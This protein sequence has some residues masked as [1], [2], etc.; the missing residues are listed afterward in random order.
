MFLKP[1]QESAMMRGRQEHNTEALLLSK[2]TRWC[3]RQIQSQP[4][5]FNYVYVLSWI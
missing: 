5:E 2:Y 4:S 1:K 3:L